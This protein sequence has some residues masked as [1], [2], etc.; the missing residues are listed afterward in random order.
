[1]LIRLHLQ[2]F[3][4]FA[5]ATFDVSPSLNV[6]VGTNGTGKTMG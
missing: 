2:N 5:D 3:T 1:M 4:V 6:L